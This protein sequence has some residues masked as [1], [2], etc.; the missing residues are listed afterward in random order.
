MLS[1]NL[2]KTIKGALALLTCAA[3]LCVFMPFAGAFESVTELAGKTKLASGVYYSGDARQ[4]EYRL[5]Y[6]PNETVRPVVVY[7][8]KVCSRGSFSEMAALLEESGMNVI[9]G[10]NGDYY[11]L[12]NGQPLGLVITE[13]EINSSDAGLWAVGFRSDGT[14][15]IGKPALDMHVYLAGENYGIAGINKVRSG[16]GY[17][18]FT[19]DF[20]ATTKNSSPGWD[21]ILTPEDGAKLRPNCEFTATVDSVIESAGELAIP[22]GKLV[23]SVSADTD[24]WRRYG[25]EHTSPGDTVRI[26]ISADELWNEAEYAVGSLMKLVTDGVPEPDLERG[27]IAPRTAVG[28]RSDGTVVLYTVDGRQTGYSKGYSIADLAERL[29][30]IGCVEACIMDGGGSTALSALYIGGEDAEI[31]GK[32]S[33]GSERSVSTYIMLAAFGEGSGSVKCIGVRPETL[34]ALKGA[35]IAFTV[36]AADETGR[37]AEL[38][39]A[40]VTASGASITGDGLARCTQAGTAEIKARFGSVEGTASVQVVETPDAIM[41]YS[42]NTRREKLV[43]PPDRTLDLSA[44]SSWMGL[45]LVSQDDNYT[46][47]TTVGSVTAD[48]VFFSGYEE[49]EG[50]I[51]VTAGGLTK[52]ISV[53]V[54]EIS[55]MLDDFETN[56]LGAPNA[57]VFHADSGRGAARLRCDLGSGGS[58]IW[59]SVHSQT[60]FAEYMHISVYGDGSGNTLFLLDPKGDR[61]T[62]CTLDFVGLRRFSVPCASMFGIGVSGS[63]KTDICVDSLVASS[64]AEPDEAAPVISDVSLDGDSFFARVSDAC[65]GERISLA[66]TLDGKP[67]KYSYSGGVLS[68]SVPTGGLRKL[69]LRATDVSGNVSEW[70]ALTGYADPVSADSD[71]SRD[72]A[73]WAVG[74]GMIELLPD[75]RFA[76]GEIM[77]RELFARAVSVWMGVDTEAY[78]ST[79][80]SF[81]DLGEIS[82]ACLPYVRAAYA[83][84]ILKGADVGGVIYFLPND[85]LTRAQA[86]TVIGRIQG[87]GYDE[88]PLSFTDADD[89]Q[90]WSKAYVVQLVSRGVIAGYDD[91]RLDPSGP[92]TRGQVAKILTMVA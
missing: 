57:E 4:A 30:Q 1:R 86:M 51:S 33:A 40:D 58:F 27:E 20:A 80:L 64:Y 75:G 88:A 25:I 49:A 59:K 9:G 18:L 17:H 22:E 74:A 7:G 13:G 78:A 24:W 82:A 29:S 61:H 62:V 70:G 34:A 21:V 50:E 56:T 36:A 90:E 38:T 55:K 46:W 2:K 76:P 77:T 87:M 65:D 32:P 84:G 54:H 42:G 85:G 91:G 26:S 79:E 83:L 23:L 81:A 8:Q 37:P 52:T 67:L 92:L 41:L 14:A 69:T 10:I 6:E 43:I 11:V 15:F 47:K 45:E 53:S 72:Y 12:A 66:L 60:D 39:Y 48:G 16:T 35:E 19:E 5:E 3:L 31:V 63:G 89:I 44:K 68:A 73:A 71:W 28:I